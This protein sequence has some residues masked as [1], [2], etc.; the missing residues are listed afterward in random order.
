M[1]IMEYPYRCT[2]ILKPF[3]MSQGHALRAGI[4][5]FKRG[6]FTT[7]GY[8]NILFRDLHNEKLQINTFTE[9][10]PKISTD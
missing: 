8:K 10:T 7:N 5:V 6:K 3:G 9:R 4:I 2:I 1:S